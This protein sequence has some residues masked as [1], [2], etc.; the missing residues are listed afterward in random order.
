MAGGDVKGLLAA[1]DDGNLDVDRALAIGIDVCRALEHA[2]A[3]GIVHRDLKPA[4]VWLDDEGRARLG[5]FGLAATGPGRG[6]GLVGTVAYLPPEQALGRT[7]GP[8]ADLYSLGAL[9]Y[10]MICGQPPF[11]GDEAVAVIGQHLS[12]EPVAPSRHNP[13]VT[14]SSTC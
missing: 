3:C 14:P 7:T 10:E 1:A 12:A 4:N 6:G 13:Q 5:D 2:H 11:T 9:L 8:R